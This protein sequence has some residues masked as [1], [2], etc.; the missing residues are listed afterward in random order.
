MSITR[1]YTIVSSRP[2]AFAQLNATPS[3]STAAAS[4]RSTGFALTLSIIPASA[5][6][7]APTAMITSLANVASS[8]ATSCSTYPGVRS[9]DTM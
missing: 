8:W 4:M 5:L 6:L 3:R 7:V 9:T 2:S 1:P